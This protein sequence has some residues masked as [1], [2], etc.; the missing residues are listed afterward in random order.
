MTV[1]FVLRLTEKFSFLRLLAAPGSS[2]DLSSGTMVIDPAK[3]AAAA[4]P[5]GQ[6]TTP[7][8]AQASVSHTSDSDDSSDEDDDTWDDFD[9]QDGTGLSYT[10]GGG[11]GVT[12]GLRQPTLALFPEAG[13][14]ELKTFASAAEA[15]DAASAQGCDMVAVV[16]RLGLDALAVIRLLNHLRREPGDLAPV[17]ISGLTGSEP[18]LLDDKELLPVPGSEND[19]LLRACFL[20]KL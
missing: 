16:Q 10:E 5:V 19:G 6:S 15:L 1:R 17:Q 14:K 7:I 18:F 4:A 8:A 9:D 20:L 2:D 13:S 12:A 3:V 11:S